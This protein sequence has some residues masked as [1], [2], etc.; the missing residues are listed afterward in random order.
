MFKVLT[1]NGVA[2]KLALGFGLSMAAVFLLAGGGVKAV[3]H[4]EASLP[5][6]EV[7]AKQRCAINFRGS[8][9]DRAISLRDTTLVTDSRELQ[10]V[11]EE[12]DTLA[13]AY[14]KSAIPLDEMMAQNATPEETAILERIKQTERDTMP[15]IV[16]VSQSRLSGDFDTAKELLMSEARPLFV[17]WLAQINEFIDLQEATIQADT[18]VAKT[19]AAQVKIMLMVVCGLALL[20]MALVA[21]WITRG[22]TR[23]IRAVLG[24]LQAVAHGDLQQQPLNLQTRGELGELGHA[25]DQMV[26]TLRKIIQEVATSTGDVVAGVTEITT[27]SHEVARGM[28]EQSNKTEQIA[29]AIEEMSCSSSEVAQQTITASDNAK[30]SGDLAETGG[31]VVT[32]TIADMEAIEYIVSSASSSINSLG[33]KSS[34]IGEVI[35]VINDIADQTN[36]LALNA[37]IEAARAGEHGRGFAV[38]ADEVRKL[39]DRTV[40]ATQEISGSIEA[41][42]TEIAGA[43]TEIDGGADKVKQSVGRA[44]EAKANLGQIVNSAQDVARMVSSIA[45]SAS[46]QKN[47]AGEITA[48]VT[49]ISTISRESN[50]GTQRAAD[51][52]QQLLQKT[53]S[54]KEIISQ[55]KM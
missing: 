29:S 18:Q 26:A 54:L 31:Q 30:R 27:L 34:Q 48:A 15:L 7:I 3:Q 49:S 50:E 12:I 8:V 39:A 32:G 28:G 45:E 23:P 16:Q 53:D 33:I 36:L 19:Q 47:A 14:T 38:V 44:A 20:F 11:L 40:Q 4:V 22:L 43:V 41:I 10:G 55:F 46:Q 6:Q 37:A 17:Q 1:R 24:S 35:A 21:W 13:A 42:R 5:T 9:H 25:T 2:Q 51:A 52:A